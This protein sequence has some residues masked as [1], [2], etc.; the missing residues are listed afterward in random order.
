MTGSKYI[1]GHTYGV[2]TFKL[3]SFAVP[4]ILMIIALA[5]YL[6]KVKLTEKRHEE[7]VAELEER[8]K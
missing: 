7:I 1:A 8:L 4:A 6:F 2:A 3:Y 5:V